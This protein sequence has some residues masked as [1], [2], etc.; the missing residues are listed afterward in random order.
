MF[1]VSLPSVMRRILWFIILLLPASWSQAGRDSLLWTGIR[2]AGLVYRHGYGDSAQAQALSLLPVAKEHNNTVAQALLHAIIGMVYGDKGN[3]QAAFDEFNLCISLAEN[4]RFLSK[5]A[6]PQYQFLFQTMIPTYVRQALLCDELG[7]QGQSIENA[8]NAL[9]WMEHS[10]NERICALSMPGVSDILVKHGEYKLAY[11]PTKKALKWCAAH[12]QEVLAKGLLA[13]LV[14]IETALNIEEKGD[15]ADTPKD[16]PD[17][18]LSS[19]QVRAAAD[20]GVQT[21]DIGKTAITAQTADSASR[22]TQPTVTHTQ[23]INIRDGRAGIIGVFLVI[24]LLLF[25]SY[26]LWQHRQRRKRKEETVQ[27][28]EER[29]IEGQESERAR[30]ARELHDGVSNQLL[31]VELKLSSDGLTPQT[32]QLLNESREQVRRVSHELLPP[33]FT[34]TTLCEVIR[35][36]ADGQDGLKGCHICF[37]S[38]PADADWTIIP[39]KTALEIYRI[40]QEAVANAQKHANAT[41]ISI[42]LHW[43]DKL[44]LTMTVSDDG[45]EE[46]G[47]QTPAGIGLR[48][49]RQRASAIGAQFDLYKHQYGNTIKLTVEFNKSTDRDDKNE[50]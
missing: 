28:M 10:N 24:V 19:E 43:E 36:Y 8:K 23:Y 29:F 33:E 22:I 50:K 34:H 13:S 20:T 26:I 15:T 32:M 11:L 21:P 37:M 5:A 3:K 42:G 2:D 7:L 6:Q 38:S 4:N 44:K 25:L 14:V 41:I 47:R 35:D 49:M 39:T 48:T 18:V 16:L 27:Q 9:K 1:F 46:I 45:V 17:I 30:L 12:K 31:A 40:M